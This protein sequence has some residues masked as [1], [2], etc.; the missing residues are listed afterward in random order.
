MSKRKGSKRAHS[1]MHMLST[2]KFRDD[3]LGGQKDYDENLLAES[4]DDSDDNEALLKDEDDDDEEED[5][6][7][8]E[9]VKEKGKGEE[10]FEMS[11]SPA[12]PPHILPFLLLDYAEEV[13][14]SCTTMSSEYSPEEHDKLI[15]ASKAL[16]QAK[17]V[18]LGLPKN[19][20]VSKMFDK[21]SRYSSFI[22]R[23]LALSL[24]TTLTPLFLF[25]LSCFRPVS[26]CS[27]TASMMERSLR[28]VTV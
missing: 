18:L 5:G 27:S 13:C 28:A 3:L 4:S 21:V 7:E 2:K 1:E 17:D 8:E 16:D 6:V 14:Y 9:E 10:E 24:H 15:Q 11:D 22:S 26:A 12:V 23:F 25:S 19:E 20:A